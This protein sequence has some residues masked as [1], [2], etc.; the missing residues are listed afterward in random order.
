MT[1]GWIKLRI[2]KMHKNTH[3]VIVFIIYQGSAEGLEEMVLREGP[4]QP[5]SRSLP[6]G[7]NPVSVLME[8][9]QRTRSPIDFIMTKQAGP[10]HDTRY[11]LIPLLLKLSDDVSLIV[12]ALF[13]AVLLPL[14]GSLDKLFLVNLSFLM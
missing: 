14:R 9:S 3:N 8:Y 1:D 2:T 13:E 7:K 6:G 12:A 5:L 10:P 11:R 4:L